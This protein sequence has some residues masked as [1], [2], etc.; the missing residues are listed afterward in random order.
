M[1]FDSLSD[2]TIEV[3]YDFLGNGWRLFEGMGN[4]AS[5]KLFPRATHVF[6]ERLGEI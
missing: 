5:E 1:K 4:F 2:F 3:S 6:Q